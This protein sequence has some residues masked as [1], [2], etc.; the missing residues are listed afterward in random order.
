MDVFRCGDGCV[1]IVDFASY[2]HVSGSR[3]GCRGAL[4]G[5][6]GDVKIVIDSCGAE[7]EGERNEWRKR[8]ARGR[9][10]RRTAHIGFVDWI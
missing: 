5:V 2:G 3:D 7:R 8:E 6:C 9:R 1:G 10:R 4:R